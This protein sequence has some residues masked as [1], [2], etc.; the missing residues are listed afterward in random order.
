M[1]PNLPDLPAEL[2]LKIVD[3]YRSSHM[4]KHLIS[5][6]RAACRETNAKL[7]YFLGSAYFQDVNVKLEKEQMLHFQVVCS[8]HLG[9]HIKGICVDAT[10][11]I[12]ET[13]RNSDTD[14]TNAS[15]CSW[16]SED[17][18]N[19]LYLCHDYFAFDEKVTDFVLTGSF[20]T[21]LGQSLTR[22]PNLE[23]FSIQSPSV[24]NTL[25]RTKVKDLKR[26]WLIA[27]ESALTQG[28]ARVSKLQELVTE[29]GESLAP[30]P[31][32]ALRIMTIHGYG[33]GALRKLHLELDIDVSKS[34]SLRCKSHAMTITD[35]SLALYPMYSR[36]LSQLLK[37]APALTDLALAFHAAKAE[38]FK[39]LAKAV[40]DMRLERLELSHF[41]TRYKYLAMF[42]QPCRATLR[43]LKLKDVDFT[44]ENDEGSVFRYLWQELDL[45]ECVLQE[46][47]VAEQGINFDAVNQQR[48]FFYTGYIER[49]LVS[50]LDGEAWSLVE[51]L[52]RNPKALTLSSDDYDD[53]GEWLRI[54]SQEFAF[55]PLW[56]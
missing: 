5:N 35:N 24:Y 11:L 23:R 38:F 2:L 27:A 37:N 3:S 19:D 52:G 51:R 31:V 12:T 29:C 48:P 47:N 32:S 8:G 30:T 42:L 43:S 17:T 21:I 45:D 46:L 39:L 20:A 6:L 9:P 25:N 14:S 56:E 44:R 13:N 33:M 26:R 4:H 15:L 54:A 34:E 10:T 53:V 1:A 22:L 36:L 49:C 16:Y 40:P 55:G 41:V 7:V 28:L 18:R 50:P